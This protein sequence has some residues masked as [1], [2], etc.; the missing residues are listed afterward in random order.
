MKEGWSSPFEVKKDIERRERGKRD[1]MLFVNTRRINCF[2][3]LCSR[4][5]KVEFWGKRERGKG[6]VEEIKKRE[7]RGDGNFLQRAKVKKAQIC[8]KKH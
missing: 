5:N 4:E 7:G 3:E 2:L 1:R 8:D 6:K